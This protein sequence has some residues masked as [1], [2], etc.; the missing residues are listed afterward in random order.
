MGRTFGLSAIRRLL[1]HG[2]GG[3]CFLA[4]RVRI[5]RGNCSAPPPL[6][7]LAA[8][9]TPVVFRVLAALGF[10]AITPVF[11]G[12]GRRATFGPRIIVVAFRA[13]LGLER[14]EGPSSADGAALPRL[15][16][17]PL[18]TPLLD[19]GGVVF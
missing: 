12:G 8:L 6:R 5:E 13:T 17:Q 14:G 16:A 2:S 4:T 1:L 18:F 9:L 7:F 15:P 19:G 11:G 10:S 3:R